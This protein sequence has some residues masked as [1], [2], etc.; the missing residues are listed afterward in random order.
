MTDTPKTDDQQPESAQ[1]S[2]SLLADHKDLLRLRLLP[3]ELAK[4]LNVTK[5]T[6][7]VWIKDGKITPPSPI[8]G[9]LDAQAAVRQVLRNT[10]PGKIRA[11]ILRQATEDAQ[12]LRDNLVHAEDRAVAAEAELQEA[13]AEIDHLKAWIESAD[14]AAGIFKTLIVEY[15]DALRAA[16]TEDWPAH[17]GKLAVRADETADGFEPGSE[18]GD[19]ALDGLAGAATSMLD[20]LREAPT[21]DGGGGD[22]SAA[23]DAP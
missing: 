2:L 20:G 12:A 11:R 23:D 16:P 1:Q 3:V 8:D 10:P 15:A 7:S 18:A 13:R 4:V 21:Q 9:R 14:R 19:D 5:Q 17:L 22:C 6:I